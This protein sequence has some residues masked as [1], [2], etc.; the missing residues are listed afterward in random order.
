M[1]GGPRWR[2]R[3]GALNPEITALRST[4]SLRW[5]AANYD[6]RIIFMSTCSVYGA[7]DAVPDEDSPAAPPFR[8]RAQ[9]AA[10]EHLRNSDA[11]IFGLGTLFDVGDL[12][13]RSSRPGCEHLTVRALPRAISV[14]GGDRSGPSCVRDAAKAVVTPGD[15]SIEVFNLQ[16]RMCASSI[17]HQVRNH[18]PILAIEQTPMKFRTRETIASAARRRGG[19]GFKANARSTMR[20]EEVKSL[21]VSLGF[22]DVENPRYTNQAFLAKFMTHHDVV[23]GMSPPPLDSSPGAHARRPLC[24]R[25]RAP[26]FRERFFIRNTSSGSYIVTNHRAGFVRAAWHKLEEPSM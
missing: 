23:S 15:V 6:R 21:L 16:R 9:L 3:L 8:V 5:L 1:A 4:R 26:E 2:R 19:P 11:L 25:S 17:R 20:I 7:R 22:W 18:F 13:S 14:L 24:R 10:E 12:F